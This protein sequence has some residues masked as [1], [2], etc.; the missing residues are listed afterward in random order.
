MPRLARPPGRPP[1]SAAPAAPMPPGRR[2][3]RAWAIW[4]AWMAVI[5]VLY[6]FMQNMFARP[7]V[8]I[9]EAGEL[10]L[11]RQRDGHFYVEGAI[12]RTPVIFMIDTGASLVAISEATAR[13]AGLEGG[14]PRT[15]ATAGGTRQGRVQRADAISLGAPGGFVLRDIE[16][17]IGLE[18]GSSGRQRQKGQRGQTS[19]ALLG[20][21]VLRHFH[22]TIA[23]DT[24]RLQRK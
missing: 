1:E 23:G 10:Q 4:L 6:L 11:P 16:V 12:N 3:V 24:M 8:F 20:Q 18:M 2:P 5:G 17:G 22:I 14:A 9:A 21:N 19:H 13:A 7:S 15:F